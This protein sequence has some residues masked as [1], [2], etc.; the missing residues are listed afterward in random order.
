MPTVHVPLPNIPGST[1]LLK[2]VQSPSNSLLPQ[3]MYSDHWFT[4]LS[5][6]GT[7]NIFTAAQDFDIN[8][9]GPVFANLRAND[10]STIGFYLFANVIGHTQ[11]TPWSPSHAGSGSNC[12][13]PFMQVTLRREADFGLQRL[14]SYVRMP[15]TPKSYI[16]T[17]DL[18]ATGEG[19]YAVSLA[20]YMMVVP[21]QGWVFAPAYV[22]RTSS[23]VAPLVKIERCKGLRVLRKRRF[24]D[25]AVRKYYVWPVVS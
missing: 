21:T 4:R 20:N 1:I 17:D 23:T 16:A 2:T 19:V 22:S 5:G 11:C 15:P 6:S 9:F 10:N 18:N 8:W 14:I 3:G 7:F 12:L 25:V 24:K 13:A